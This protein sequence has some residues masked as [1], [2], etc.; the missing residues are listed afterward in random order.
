[1]IKKGDRVKFISDTTSGIVSS[2]EGNIANITIEDGFEI[3]ALLDDLVVVDA[4]EEKEAIKKMGIGDGN[5]V[6]SKKTEKPNKEKK[7]KPR[8]YGPTYGRISLSSDYEDEDPIDI[9]S[10][11]KNYRRSF[12]SSVDTEN[13]VVSAERIDEADKTDYE[14]NLC[15]VPENPTA[16]QDS[17]KWSVFLVNDSSYSVMYSISKQENKYAVNMGYGILEKDSK[18]ELGKVSRKHISEM[19]SLLINLILFKSPSR[20]VPQSTEDFTL[21]INPLKLTKQGNYEDNDFFEEKVLIFTL[22]SDKEKYRAE[23]L[24][25]TPPVIEIKDEKPRSSR[26]NTNDEPEIIDLHIQEILDDTSGMT[27][28]E[29]IQAQ[30]SRFEIAL[31]LALRSNHRKKMVFIHGVGSGKLKY[32]MQKLMKIKYPRIRYQDASFKEYG[33]GAMMVFI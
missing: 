13:T 22:G 5:P 31:D 16:P 25:I 29:I 28:G 12:Q 17:D 24:K 3:P 23:P 21:E 4:S 8:S 6:G 14:L 32:E 30:L 33:Y 20:F 18:I 10:L 7:K 26:Q 11:R 9:E 1:M 2:I 19:F 27:P 15:F